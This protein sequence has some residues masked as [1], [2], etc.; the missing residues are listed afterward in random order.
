MG[1][2]IVNVNKKAVLPTRARPEAEIRTGK[3]W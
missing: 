3:F 2:D 1:F